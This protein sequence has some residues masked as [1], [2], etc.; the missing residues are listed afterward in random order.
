M[1]NAREILRWVSKPNAISQDVAYSLLGIFDI[2]ALGVWQF[3]P[4][5]VVTLGDITA[6]GNAESLF[7]V[8]I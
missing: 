4:K 3:P 8:S 2:H 1:T 7:Q 6:L 5:I